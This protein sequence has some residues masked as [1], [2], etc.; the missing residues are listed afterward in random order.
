MWAIVSAGVATIYARLAVALHQGD[1][2]ADSEPIITARKKPP[3]RKKSEPAN[4]NDVPRETAAQK[5]TIGLPDINGGKPRSTI[6]NLNALLKFHKITVRYNVI[7]KRY[8]INIPGEDFSPDNA[9]NSKLARIISRAMEIGMPATQIKSYVEFIGDKNQ[10]NPGLDWVLSKPWDG[11]DYVLQLC[12]TIVAKN[13]HAKKLFIRRWLITAVQMLI[14]NGL[15]S[16]CCLVLQGGQG[17]GKTWWFR[18]LCPVEGLVRTG[19]SVNP[20]NRDS[21][22]QVIRYWIVELGEIGSTFLKSDIDSIKAFITSDMDILRRPWSML[23]QTYPR[24]TALA[25][26]VNEHTFLYDPTGNRRYLTIE[27]ISVNSYHAIDMQQV[28]A[29]IYDEI[30]QGENHLLSDEEKRLVDEINAEHVQIDPTVESLMGAYYWDSAVNGEE[31]S[32]TAIA[33]AIGL[34]VVSQ[35]ETRTISS[36][37]RKLGITSRIVDGIAIYQMPPKK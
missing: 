28:F 22:S 13:E 12:G 29:Q 17:I 33:H 25:A 34:K 15:D 10:Y 32:S 11:E 18:K 26:S 20:H 6:E 9:D 27:C 5:V 8:E 1:C 24:R 2:M 35:K 37:L 23:D 21:V 14:N 16:A 36:K 7:S 4:E 30:C 3:R 19:A 31:K